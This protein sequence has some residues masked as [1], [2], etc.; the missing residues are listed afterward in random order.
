MTLPASVLQ[1]LAVAVASLGVAG[2]G[3]ATS[4]ETPNTPSVIEPKVGVTPEGTP[5]CEPGAAPKHTSSPDDCP[6]C[7]QG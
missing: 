3:S 2:C 5:G 4:N 1:S 7:G 6:A